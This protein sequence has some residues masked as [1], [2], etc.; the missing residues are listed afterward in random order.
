MHS[1]LRPLAPFSGANA[2]LG[3]VS[4]GALHVGCVLSGVLG[5]L[6]MVTAFM[7]RRGPG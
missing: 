4:L 7:R 6:L 3:T 5:A 2:L 1:D